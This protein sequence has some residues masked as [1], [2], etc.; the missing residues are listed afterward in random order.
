MKS[1]T[2]Q[3]AALLAVFTIAAG[4][5]LKN[6]IV[7]PHEILS[8]GPPKD[9][10]PAILA[11]KF[12]AVEQADFLRDSDEVIGVEVDGEARAYPIRILNWHEI[13]NDTVSG[14]PIAVTF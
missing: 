4:F 5:D 6:A 1:K 13:V 12:A 3:T 8:G 9:G 10:I 7:P 14:K 11:P 2:W